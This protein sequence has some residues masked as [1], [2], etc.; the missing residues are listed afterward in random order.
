MIHTLKL[1]KTNQR[2]KERGNKEKLR[3]NNFVNTI[4]HL[5]ISI[6][7]VEITF[8]IRNIVFHKKYSTKIQS[9]ESTNYSHNVMD[10]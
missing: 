4:N 8:N 5:S 7:N 10:E 6:D 1:Q 2:K 3:Q 9:Q